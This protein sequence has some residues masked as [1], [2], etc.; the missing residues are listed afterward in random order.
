MTVQI[1]RENSVTFKITSDQ[2]VD[3]V[4]IFNDIMDKCLEEAKK[5]GFRNMFN[6]D[7]KSF[8]IEFVKQLKEIDYET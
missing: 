5:K 7:E 4:G 6:K 8:L 1:Y 3:S 2:E